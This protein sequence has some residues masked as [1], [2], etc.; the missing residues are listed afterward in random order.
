LS[1]NF[2][3]S[4]IF[5]GTL[6]YTI[7]NQRFDNLGFG[8]AVRGG[9]FQ[10]YTIVDNIPLVWSKVTGGESTFSLPGNWYTVH[11]RLGVNFV[12]GNRVKKKPLP[13]NF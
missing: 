2:N 6:A 10:F 13:V 11:A 12:F 4:N 8:I 9:F 3:L 7:A 5:S 1:G